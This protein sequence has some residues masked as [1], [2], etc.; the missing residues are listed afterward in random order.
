[1]SGGSSGV[2]GSP[3]LPDDTNGAE[4]LRLSRRRGQLE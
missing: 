3:T 2:R 1:M 4:R